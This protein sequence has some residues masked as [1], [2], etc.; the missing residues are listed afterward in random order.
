MGK[1]HRMTYDCAISA[2]G[3]C[4]DSTCSCLCHVPLSETEFH[5]ITEAPR[6]NHLLTPTEYKV[7]ELVAQGFG[8]IQIA[9]KLR[10]TPQVAKNVLGHIY[11]KVGLYANPRF[12]PMV[13][14]GVWWNC[15]LF[16]KGLSA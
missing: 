9:K 11:K 10:T 8:T 7:A 2:H 15:E 16:Q 4:K 12:S 3:L 5:V 6:G 14:L 13:Q 1:G